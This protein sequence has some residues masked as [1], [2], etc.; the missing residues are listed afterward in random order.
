MNTMNIM[1]VKFPKKNP[2]NPVYTF[3][4]SIALLATF[5]TG[6]IAKTKNIPNNP[7]T[8]NV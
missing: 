8:K 3:A 7:I 6:A 2:A 4:L 1:N 5:V